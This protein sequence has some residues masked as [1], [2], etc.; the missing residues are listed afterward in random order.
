M[1]LREFKLKILATQPL[2][3]ADSP[4]CSSGNTRRV[5]CGLTV[6]PDGEF[7]DLTDPLLLLWDRRPHE[8]L[9]LLVENRD[10][11]RAAALGGKLP[12]TRDGGTGLLTPELIL[13]PQDNKRSD[14]LC[15]SNSKYLP[16]DEE[17]GGC[18]EFLTS[19][20]AR[21]SLRVISSVF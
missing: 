14:T 16:C 2:C 1:D 12:N 8:L 18:V 3:R 17:E 9:K 6:Q 21:C 11:V 13:L 19:S 4:S 5:R 7:C 15:D 10:G 20:M